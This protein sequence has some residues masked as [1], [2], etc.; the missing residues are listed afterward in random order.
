MGASASAAK[1]ANVN[2]SAPTA[3][4]PFVVESWISTQSGQWI[5][6]GTSRKRDRIVHWKSVQ[7]QFRPGSGSG[8]G[9]ASCHI[10][11]GGVDDDGGRF[12]IDNGVLDLTTLRGSFRKGTVS[13]NFR[14]EK[15][16]K[17]DGVRI[18]AVSKEAR[19]TLE[20][21]Q[22]REHGR[23]VHVLPTLQGQ[24]REHG[25][26]GHDPPNHFGQSEGKTSEEALPTATA[27]I[28]TAQPLP[29]PVCPTPSPS[30]GAHPPNAIKVE[31]ALRR[32]H[33]YTSL[34]DQD[35]APSTT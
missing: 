16:R 17:D 23:S 20:K 7:L 32:L 14:L 15:S 27:A 19:I 8:S 25:P 2:G 28:P 11:G 1:P 13:Y 31:G 24:G 21:H 29:S 35:I 3:V 4:H 12:V 18:I 5:G 6:H 26:N 30:L 22:G 9:S 34:V 33:S 10:T